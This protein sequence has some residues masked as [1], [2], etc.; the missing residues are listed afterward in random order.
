MKAECR[1]RF[2]Q[3]H[4]LLKKRRFRAV[5]GRLID[6]GTGRI[7]SAF[8]C[9]LNHAWF[10]CGETFFLRSRWKDAIQAYR[11][12]YARDQTDWRAL[13]AIGNCYDKLRKPKQAMHYLSRAVQIS[14]RTAELRYNLGNALFDLG[15]LE[16]AVNCYRKAQRGSG[17]VKRLAKRNE[18][19][20]RARIERLR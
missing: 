15:R 18:K 17:Q 10:V 14:P 19:R 5:E 7:K 13:M 2:S 12:A 20:A 16:D 9:D 11:K 6:E 4:G 1:K 3:L 8:R